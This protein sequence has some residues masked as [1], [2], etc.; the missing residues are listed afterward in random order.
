MI[1]LMESFN[2]DN[3]EQ[4]LNELLEAAKN[5]ESIDRD[6]LMAVIA[7]LLE[8]DQHLEELN[9]SIETVQFDFRE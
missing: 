4:E 9:E 8:D 2:L 1:E 6:E 5:G 7:K 3:T